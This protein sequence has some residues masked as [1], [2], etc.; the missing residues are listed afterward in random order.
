MATDE[1]CVG[2]IDERGFLKSLYRKGFTHEKC[3]LELV[4]NTLDAQD[5][6]ARYQPLEKK[7]VFAIQRTFIRMT[8]NG[9]GMDRVAAENMFAM[10]RENHSDDTSR[11]VSG[12]G[13]KPAL[14]ILSDKK[15]VHIYTRKLNGEYLCITV[16]WDEI[17]R[18]GKYTGMVKIRLMNDAE[19][20]EFDEER[21]SAHGTTIKFPYNDRLKNTIEA[22]FDYITLDGKP[23]DRIGVVFGR[24]PIECIYKHFEKPDDVRTL[25]KYNYF[26]GMDTN[27]YKGRSVD[28]IQQWQAQDKADR[29]IWNHYGNNL[30]ITTRG[31]GFTKEPAPST[32]SMFGY[33]NVGTFEVKTG[34]CVDTTLFDS[35]HPSI[36]STSSTDMI[37][38]YHTEYLGNDCMDFLGSY[39]L[40]RNDQLIGLIPPPDSK[41]SNA[42]A[43][44]KAMVE[45][46][47][48]QCDISFNPI[49]SQDN[50][51]DHAMNIQENKNQYD[52]SSVDKRFTRL[53]AAIKKQKLAEIWSYF[54]EASTPVVVQDEDE[55]EPV[56]DTPADVPQGP[57]TEPVPDGPGTEPVPDAPVPD[58]PVPDAPVPVNEPGTL[59]IID[60]LGGDTPAA[61][62]A[63]AVAGGEAAAAGDTSADETA[64]GDAPADETTSTDSPTPIDVRQHRRGVVYG[65]ELIDELRRVSEK[66][67]PDAE[68]TNDISIKLF[69]TLVYY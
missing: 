25:H 36:P 16:P 10:H 27:F 69:N 17:H 22:N 30:E 12:I 33:R 54:T 59:T 52:G 49:S 20:K 42:R 66:I 24:E 41:I 44:G 64:G 60:M 67:S 31:T 47:L 61:G 38:R 26:D 46:V 57:G 50:P 7:L 34:L 53:V 9:I 51:M 8:D 35:E 28:T 56:P 32:T 43:N 1:S 14:C 21:D 11:G 2:S 39:K 40:V 48:L 68:Y 6:L 63:A 18:T 45:H 4:A 3:L 23:L 65:K 37:G 55:D 29:F 62:E 13:S 5:K 19:K 15:T 58:A